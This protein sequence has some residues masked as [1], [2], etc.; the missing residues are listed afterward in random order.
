MST[1]ESFSDAV[2]GYLHIPEQCPMSSNVNR[3]LLDGLKLSF[4]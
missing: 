3:P 1:N 4:V 2:D